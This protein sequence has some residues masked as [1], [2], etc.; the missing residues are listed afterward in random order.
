MQV[1]DPETMLSAA[2]EWAEAARGFD[3]ESHLTASVRAAVALM[4]LARLDEA[5]E[6]VRRV[7]AESQRRILPRLTL[8]AGYWLAK[9][10]LERGRLEEAEQVSVELAGLAARVGD[11]PRGRNRISRVTCNVGLHRANVAEEL[12]RFAQAAAEEPSDHLQI[13]LYEDLALW[14]ART[15]GSSDSGRVGELLGEARQK[16]AVVGCPRCSGELLLMSAEALARMGQNEE[17]R[18]AVAEWDALP[19]RPKPHEQFLRT[20]IAGL[21]HVDAHEVE[22]GLAEFVESQNRSDRLQFVV[23]G[24]WTR[25]DTAAA[26]TST[27]RAQAAEILRGAAALA[28][29]AGSSTQRGIAEQRLRALGV[30]TWRRARSPTGTEPLS[31]LTEREREVARLAAAGSSNPE[32]AKALFVSRKTVERHVSNVLGKLGVRNRTELAAT[33]GRLETEGGEQKGEGAPR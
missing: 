26:L 1:D 10:L 13:G 29:E 27:D 30:R 14:V 24:L 28:D 4:L 32:I 31:C 8:D 23:E 25:L 12:E 16:A 33:L 15:G 11:V 5:E 22:K 3:E 17:A 20:R 21:L 9:V 7:W 2:E 6:R 18:T 19:P